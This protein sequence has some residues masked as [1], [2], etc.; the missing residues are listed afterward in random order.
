[1]L[2]NESTESDRKIVF[3]TFVSNVDTYKRLQFKTINLYLRI[4]PF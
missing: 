3:V 1:M 2:P 4:M